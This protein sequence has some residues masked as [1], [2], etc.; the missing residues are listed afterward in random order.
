MVVVVCC[1]V[2]FVPIGRTEL[3]HCGEPLDSFNFISETGESVSHRLQQR[4]KWHAICVESAVPK[5]QLHLSVTR[6]DSIRAEPRVVS[7]HLKGAYLWPSPSSI[8]LFWLSARS[9]F[10]SPTSNDGTWI[11]Q[12]FVEQHDDNGLLVARGPPMH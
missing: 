11:S 10:I 8:P 7:R 9:I 3:G 4:V 12:N 5:S 6:S 1:L 2:P